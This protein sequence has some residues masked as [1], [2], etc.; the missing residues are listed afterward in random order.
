MR[1]RTLEKTANQVLDASGFAGCQKVDTV[2]LAAS[3]GFRVREAMNLDP[4]TD[5]A[6]A[7]KET[8]KD[9]YV[10]YN[11]PVDVKRYMIAYEL[12]YY[13]L[14]C[15]GDT[16]PVLHKNQPHKPNTS[17]ERDLDY[18]TRCILMPADTFLPLYK[19]LRKGRA[20]AEI[21]WELQD[22]FRLRAEVIET[23]LRDFRWGFDLCHLNF[24]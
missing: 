14:H 12:A 20:K 1:K 6:L 9:I 21:V 13:I 4:G 7:V 10:N 3:C 24:I 22:T 8:G 16:S 18:L 23:R 11:L 19:R 2:A 5:G 17:G 15:G